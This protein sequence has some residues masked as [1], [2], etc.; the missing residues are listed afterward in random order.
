M[1]PDETVVVTSAAKRV[2]FRVENWATLDTAVPDRIRGERLIES[3]D[4]ERSERRS[5]GRSCSGDCD[6]VLRGESRPAE[7]NVRYNRHCSAD[8]EASHRAVLD[9]PF[10]TDS[11]LRCC[12]HGRS[13]G[14]RSLEDDRDGGT[15]LCD[16]GESCLTVADFELTLDVNVTEEFGQTLDSNRTHD[17]ERARGNEG[18]DRDTCTGDGHRTDG[19]VTDDRHT[20]TECG[21]TANGERSDISCC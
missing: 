11:A 18:A 10:A 5:R 9:P 19:G 6:W 21:S 7:A 12:V 14:E 15:G 3:V 13:A 2:T 17:R 20:A 1:L 8:R 4:W 16:D